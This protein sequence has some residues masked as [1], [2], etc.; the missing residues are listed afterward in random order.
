MKKLISVLMLFVSLFCLS[1][2]G[3]KENTSSVYT[4][5]VE[6]A[7]YLIKQGYEMHLTDTDLFC[8]VADVEYIEDCKVGKHEGY[9][10]YLFDLYKGSDNGFLTFMIID[11]YTSE[12][13]VAGITGE[14]LIPIEQYS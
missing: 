9:L 12:I 4:V 8:E 5:T 10:F 3:E 11:K 13:F 1:S 6:Q 7:A 2:C 14:D